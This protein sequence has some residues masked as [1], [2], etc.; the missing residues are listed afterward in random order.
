MHNLPSTF[1]RASV[2]RTTESALCCR[3][4]SEIVLIS[5]VMDPSSF[6]FCL[7]LIKLC[8]SNNTPLS[9]HCIQISFILFKFYNLRSQSTPF[10]FFCYTFSLSS[11]FL[12]SFS[13]AL[14]NLCKNV[15]PSSLNECTERL[16]AIIQKWNCKFQVL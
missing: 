16:L 1:S 4:A 10:R 11:Q 5:T 7:S 3:P 6:I 15:I 13:G 9:P 14:K 8:L 2:S 12:P